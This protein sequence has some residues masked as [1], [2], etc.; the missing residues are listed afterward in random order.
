MEANF[1]GPSSLECN[2]HAKEKTSRFFLWQ[3]VE[4]YPYPPLHQS[5][6]SQD[7]WKAII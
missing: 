3:F 6:P 5:N 1:T 2:F 7:D 4:S